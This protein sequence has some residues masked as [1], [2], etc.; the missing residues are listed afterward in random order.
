MVSLLLYFL[1]IITN[2]FTMAE[3]IVVS[4]LACTCV[5]PFITYLTT[6]TDASKYLSLGLVKFYKVR[7]QGLYCLNITQN[8]LIIVFMFWMQSCKCILMHHGFLWL[9]ANITIYNLE[10]KPYLILVKRNLY[11]KYSSWWLYN[12]FIYMH[13]HT[14]IHTERNTH[15]YIIN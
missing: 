2:T 15:T 6:S 5:S 8:N 13:T 10:W 7:D 1:F 3:R 4:P 9:S 12:I 14:H 11:L